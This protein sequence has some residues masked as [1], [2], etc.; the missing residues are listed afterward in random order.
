MF[1]KSENAGLMSLIG[2][3]VAMVATVMCTLA[4]ALSHFV[5]M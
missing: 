1:R 3:L 2:A 5:P 4:H